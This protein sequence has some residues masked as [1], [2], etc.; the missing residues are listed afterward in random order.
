MTLDDTKNHEDNHKL[1][2][3]WVQ[4]PSWL[5]MIMGLVENGSFGS[6]SSI[7]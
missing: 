5:S 2:G 6:D 4:N 7:M 3:G 1:V